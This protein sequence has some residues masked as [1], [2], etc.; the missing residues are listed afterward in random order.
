MSA[1]ANAVRVTVLA[2][3]QPGRELDPAPAVRE[4]VA[5]EDAAGAQHAHDLGQARGLVAA[6][7]AHVLEHAD[8]RDGVEARVRVREL[9]RLRRGCRG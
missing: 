6:R 8:R 5:D 4:V 9:H 1:R 3:A 2:A 7:L